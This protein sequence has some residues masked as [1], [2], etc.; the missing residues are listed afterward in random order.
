MS[1]I[2][3]EQH[4]LTA[5]YLNSFAVAIAAVGG[6][7]PPISR[8]SPGGTISDGLLIAVVVISLAISL[9]VH[10]TARRLL[11]RLDS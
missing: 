9:S 10:L 8:L 5:N 1:K 11:R 7:A 2:T 3:D 6:L 4:K